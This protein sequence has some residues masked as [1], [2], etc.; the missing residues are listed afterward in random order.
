[1]PKAYYIFLPDKAG[2]ITHEWNSCLKKVL[3]AQISGYRIV[4]LNYFIDVPDFSS[5]IH[6]R[7]EIIN[8]VFGK[9]RNDFP[10]VSVTIHPPCKPWKVTVEATFRSIDELKFTS[11]LS[12]GIP[13]IKLESENYKEIWAGGVSSYSNQDDTGIAAEEA[14]NLMAGILRNEGMSMNN[15]VRQWNYI[16]N[17]LAVKD[18][19]QKY[20]SFNEIRNDYYSRLRT[21]KGY[22][23]ATGVG[24]KHGG[25][26]LDFYAVKSDKSL[27]ITPIKNPNQVDAYNYG[28]QVLKGIGDQGQKVKHP[29]QFERALLVENDRNAWLHVSGTAAVIGQE[30]I[31]A[32]NI[33]RQIAISIENIIN[34]TEP[35]RINKLASVKRSYRQKLLIIRVY[36]RNQNDFIKVREV[37]EDKFP[38]VP[39][40]YVEGDLCRDDLLV[41][42]EAEIEQ[43][44]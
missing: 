19:Y 32:G 28:Q 41:E 36:I 8:S 1:M 34:L 33:S 24:M 10:A 30:T 43:I 23:A 16:G 12:G 27:I 15:L 38:G 37:C 25:V 35:E 29:P 7:K 3:A 44:L 11:N 18:G 14:F 13:Y 20:Q 5:F 6:T 4:K 2:D 40:V 39:A 22:P 42:I 17:I 31:G 26:I 9:F 21:V